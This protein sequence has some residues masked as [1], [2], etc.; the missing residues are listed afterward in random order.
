MSKLDNKIAVI[1]G[2]SDGMGLATAHL[3]A[4]EGAQVI[5]TG[6]KKDA[7]EA[8]AKAIG[9]NA[10]P[11]QGDISNLA[12]LDRLRDHIK[13]KYGRVDVIFAN[14]GGGALGPFEYVSE[15]D[16]DFTIN[17]N[18]K[19]TFFTVQKLLP[20]MP[21]GGSIILNTSVAGSKGLPAFSVY[22]ATKAALR[23]FAR[24]W[25]TDLKERGIRINALAPGH[26]A[27]QIMRKA[28]LSEEQVDGILGQLRQQVP[29][30]RLGDP[31]EIAK[32][33]LFLASDDSS[34][35][36]GIELTVDGGWA[37]I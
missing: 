23:S 37:Q 1:T 25:T 15:A 30:G 33:A 11:V 31:E 6:R 8:A 34:Y 29:L 14:A 24:T 22:S 16:F 17:T 13:T 12:D 28:G 2:G 26:I 36:S 35:V 18:L 5:I 7:L 32:P 21:N 19:G 10:D 20:L 3:F 9:N 27:T 4:K